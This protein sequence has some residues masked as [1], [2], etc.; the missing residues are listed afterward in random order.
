MIT[1]RSFL[2]AGAA[3]GALGF[4]GCDPIVSLVTKLGGQGVPATRLSET[5]AAE[6]DPA[7]HLL[8]RA[9]FGPW[10]G[11]LA[12]VGKLGA[13]AWVEEQ[14]APERI[15]DGL[16]D[17]RARRFESLHASVGELFEYRKRVVCEEL[18]RATLLRAV[19]SKRQLLE[20]MV[21]F[22]SDHLNIDIG[23]GA[24]AHLK[25]ADDRLVI[26]RH[27]LGKFRALIGASAR[28][29]AMLVYLDGVQNQKR[30]PAEV[31]NENYGR[32]LLELHTLGVEGGYTQGDVMEA[33]RCL[34]GWRVR[35]KWRK[36]QVV[37]DPRAHDDGGKVVLG[38]SIPAGGGAQDLERL[39]DIVCSHPSTARHISRKL[40]RRFVC[41]PPPRAW[42]S[43]SRRSSC[44][45]RVM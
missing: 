1:R 2:R 15:D 32:E 36:G 29:P 28:S 4:T 34:T 5:S 7:F 18:T 40:C 39:L 31:P 33:A 41:D 23:K 19:Y 20:V 26:R 14:L 30:T 12:R 38:Q 13:A 21:R 45:A 42:S 24:C 11:D 35:L 6:V 43:G 44:R 8:S 10:P 22:W 25:A 3:A 17:L 27:A 16:C 37:F 9:G